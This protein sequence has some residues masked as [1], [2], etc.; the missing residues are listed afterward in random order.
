MSIDC[1][2]RFNLYSG[3][4]VF[5]MHIG[6]TWTQDE[7]SFFDLDFIQNI[8]IFDQVGALKSDLISLFQDC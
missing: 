8:I 6:Q 5:L 1:V 3:P 2:Y 4:A 7:C